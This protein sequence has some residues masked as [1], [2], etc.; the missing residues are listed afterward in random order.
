[1]AKANSLR[2]DEDLMVLRI[3]QQQL[4]DLERCSGLFQYG[5]KN[6]CR[7]LASLRV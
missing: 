7:H 5:G 1:V 2:P 6:G 3:I 4:A